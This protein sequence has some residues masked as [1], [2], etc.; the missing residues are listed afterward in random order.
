MK[1][2]DFQNMLRLDLTCF[3]RFAFNI[4]HPH[5]QYQHNWHVDLM[6]RALTQ[7]SN[8][9]IKRLIITMPPC[10]LKSH[11]VSI[12][13][14]AWELGRDPLKKFLCLH[15]SNALGR[16]LDAAC[17]E[18]MESRRFRAL[19]PSTRIGLKK[20]KLCTSFGGHRQFMPI[21][22]RLTGLGADIIIIDDPISTTDARDPKARQLLHQQF[23]D[24]ILQR[25]N[26][27][28]DGAIVLVMQR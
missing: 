5:A 4:L 11:C 13:W 10:M 15:A 22:G 14:P 23:D 20:N 16:D 26:N 3:T 7:V 25:L 21:N 12:A 24:N 19:F 2:E 28:K 27:K 17:L 1:I 9:E 6:A 8:G 18:L